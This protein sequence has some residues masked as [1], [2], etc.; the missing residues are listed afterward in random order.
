VAPLRLQRQLRLYVLK[1]PRPGDRRHSIEVFKNDIL[2]LDQIN[3]KDFFPVPLFTASS[4]MERRTSAIHDFMDPASTS[5]RSSTGSMATSNALAMSRSNLRSASSK[6]TMVRKGREGSPLPR[7]KSTVIAKVALSR[8]SGRM[9]STD[10][11]S[12]I[13]LGRFA[14]GR[15]CCQFR[16]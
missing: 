6:P 15:I 13:R 16:P 3:A 9:G 7:T 4:S 2:G 14:E 10:R 5:S 1:Q 8:V 11:K 12:S